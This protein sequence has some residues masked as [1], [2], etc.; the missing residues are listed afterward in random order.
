MN[1]YKIT[2]Y[3]DILKAIADGHQIQFRGRSNI[4]PDFIWKDESSNNA[5]ST[6]ASLKFDPAN[7]RVKPHTMEIGSFIVPK[8]LTTHP[9]IGENY[10]VP[11]LHSCSYALLLTWQDD[12]ADMVWFNSNMCFDVRNKAV[13]VSKILVDVFKRANLAN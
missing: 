9:R 4:S 8:A 5:L 6:I 10:W 2:D 7:Y 3:A 12:E 1:E 13:Q 11:T